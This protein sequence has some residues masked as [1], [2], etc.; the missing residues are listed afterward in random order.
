VGVAKEA[1]RRIDGAMARSAEQ[2]GGDVLIRW[3]I[4]NK[5]QKTLSEQYRSSFIRQLFRKAPEDFM[6]FVKPGTV[7]EI[8]MLK[9]VLTPDE[10]VSVQRRFIG[11]I[12]EKATDP[13]TFD[14]AGE[15]VL[16]E[17]RRFRPETVTAILGPGQ[18]ESLAKFARAFSQLQ[19]KQPIGTGKVA[20]QLLQ[21]SMGVGGIVGGIAAGEPIAVAGGVAVL[22]TPWAM[23]QVMTRPA[24]RQ[25]F[26]RAVRLGA[27]TPEFRQATRRIGQ[28][29]AARALVDPPAIQPPGPV[30][31]P[32]GMEG[33]AGIPIPRGQRPRT[34]DPT[35]NAP[36]PTKPS[37]QQPRR[38][39][40]NAQGQ[41]IP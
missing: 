12:L 25:T 16:S 27:D 19:A 18:G 37:Q 30:P 9:K 15:K 5:F 1:V 36:E 41:P 29:L 28:F 33:I 39:R 31:E 6:D 10:W 24:M 20:I 38:L 32:S 8:G 34:T 3:R 13:R 11:D 40:F 4:A 23:A 35:A 22:G 17:L 26:L 7:Q 14:V 2:L 21:I